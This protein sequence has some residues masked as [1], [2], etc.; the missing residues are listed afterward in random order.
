MPRRLACT[1]CLA[2]ALPSV[3]AAQVPPV[4]G[5]ARV[6]LR[7]G[8]TIVTAISDVQGD[9][10]SIK[11]VVRTDA[12]SIRVQYSAQVRRQGVLLR[13]DVSRTVLRADLETARDYQGYFYGAGP[14]IYTG[15]TALGVSAGVLG[16]LKTKGQAEIRVPAAGMAGAEG[17]MLSGVLTRVEPA[18]VPFKVI[19]NDEP[20]A[21][22]AVHARGRLGDGA[23]E[24]WILDDPENPLALRWVIGVSRQQLQAIKLSYP[25]DPPTGAFAAST[26]AARI[27]RDLA[28]EGRA[29]V[30]GIF[31]DF[32][33]DGIREE[34][35]SVLAEIAR[36]L[37]E[38]P[39]WSLSVE[40]HTDNIGGDS[41]NLDLSRRRAAAVKRALVARFEVAGSRL[42]TSGYGASRPKDTND[43]LEGRARNRRVELVK[44]R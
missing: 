39:A 19:V 4:P 9:F 40:G 44:V 43:T 33:S 21:L 37:R 16:D 7:E 17:I 18:P 10:E 42:Q 34:S 27:E 20:T 28:K 30:Y 25:V 41:Y 32:G 35:D 3:A 1:L 2:L 29:V 23:A 24:F 13:A 12:R 15:S 5:A 22:P 11:R 26:G 6:P 31:F 8:L 38:N 14:E 36:A